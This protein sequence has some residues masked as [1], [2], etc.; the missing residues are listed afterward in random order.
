MDEREAAIACPGCGGEGQ[1]VISQ[2]SAGMGDAG[3]SCAPG[4]T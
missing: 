2:V 1:V 4:S 3:T